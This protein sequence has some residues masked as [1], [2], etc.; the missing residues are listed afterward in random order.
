MK[1]FASVI[2][3][4][5]IVEPAVFGDERGFFME[6]WNHRAFN[7]AIGRDVR[8]VQDNHSRSARGVLRGLHYQMQQAQGKLI[9]VLRGSVFDVVVDLRRASPTFGRHVAV[10]LSEDSK[11]QLWVPE[12]FAHGFLVLS[13]SADVA[14]KATDYYH[15]A[16][17]RS[18]RWNDP[19][20]G[21]DW[22]DTGNAPILSDK[23]REARHFDP[24]GEYFA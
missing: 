11:R 18:L 7:D 20:L 16:S 13:E 8:F 5:L 3:D 1:V 2:P 24:N 9:R 15:P 21:I 6:T 10:E 17:E 19:Q 12:G 23:D 4:V 14:Y 22:P